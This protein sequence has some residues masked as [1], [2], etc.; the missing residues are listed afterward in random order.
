MSSGAQSKGRTYLRI[1]CGDCMKEIATSQMEVHFRSCV[2]RAQR[3]EGERM[4]RLLHAPIET[5]NVREIVEAGRT[6]EMTAYLDT[7]G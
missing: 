1:P 3:I 4:D 6:A 7:R 5:L 2:F